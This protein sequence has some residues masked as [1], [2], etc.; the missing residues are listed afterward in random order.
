MRTVYLDLE[1][2][3][4][5]PTHDEILEIG[6]IDDDGAVLLHSQ[7][8]PLRISSWP[9]A[10]WVHG[11][12][13]EDIANAPL[14]K[15]LRPSLIAAVQ[16]A[17]VVIYNATYDSAFLR[18]ELAGAREVVCAMRAF[19]EAYGEWSERHGSWRYHKLTFAAQHV[20][21]RGDGTTHRAIADCRA[22]RAVWHWLIARD[23]T[24]PGSPLSN[25]H[26]HHDGNTPSASEPVPA[27]PGSSG[28][29][30]ATA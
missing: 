16:D 21:Y 8:H 5:D 17:R 6:V 23:Q 9:Q 4:I 29:R 25:P 20:G 7:V 13:P 18:E 24:P 15:E 30:A 10:Q 3:G 19:A 12:A 1:T 14:F 27:I 26:A 22:T 2:T 11:I 28:L